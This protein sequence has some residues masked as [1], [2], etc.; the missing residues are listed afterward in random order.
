[1]ELFCSYAGQDPATHLKIREAH[2]K[3]AGLMTGTFITDELLAFIRGAL[4]A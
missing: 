2:A 3:E 4:G 1:M